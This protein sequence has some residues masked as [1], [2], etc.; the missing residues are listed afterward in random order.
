M[1]DSSPLRQGHDPVLRPV[2]RVGVRV[3]ALTLGGLTP[4]A[5]R[6]LAGLLADPVLAVRVFSVPAPESEP[7]SAALGAVL[8]A[9][10]LLVPAPRRTALPDLPVF[11]LEPAAAVRDAALDV[12]LDLGGGAVDDGLAKAAAH[13]L[14]RVA[15]APLRDVIAGATCTEA[16]LLRHGGGVGPARIIARA[17]YDTKPLATHNAA[18][19]FE[20][21]AQVILREVKR[22]ALQGVVAD[23]GPEVLPAPVTP[24]GARAYLR[25]TAGKTVERLGKWVE[26]RRGIV[27]QGF[28]LRIGHGAPLNFDPAVARPVKMPEGGLWADPFLIAQ[29]RAVYCF[30]EDVDPVAGRGHI[31]VGRVTEA[32]LAEVQVAL[33]MPHHMSYPFVFHHDGALLMMPEVHAAGRLEIWR[34]TGFPTKWELYSTAFEGTPVADS[35]L[36]ERDGV[37]WLFTHI[38]RDRFG[39]FCSDLHVFRVDGPQ[40]TGLVPHRLNPVVTDASTARGGGRIHAAEGRLLRF[41]QDNSAGSYG[42]A[43]NVMEILRLDLEH[44]EERR[45]RHITPDFAPGLSGTHHFDALDG[46]FVI[47]VR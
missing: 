45:L 4:Q 3:G 31:S 34:C 47:D 6:L 5:V 17:V 7:L 25:Q 36:L 37:W 8:A 10:R 41:S 14:W 35:T 13:G 2:L 27:R 9:E 33:K 29:D 22:L 23:L 18:Y 15:A 24:S 16:T 20:K 32:G 11:R 19:V 26:R 38:S 28:T 1:P 39:D 40:L 46:W 21:S 44:Y 43:L 30:F 42:G 12:I